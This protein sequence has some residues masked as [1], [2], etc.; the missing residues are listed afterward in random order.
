M[1]TKH[2][3]I[4]ASK[5][6]V[7]KYQRVCEAAHVTRIAKAFDREALGSIVV[8][9]REDGSYYVVDGQHRVAA[10]RVALGVDALLPC[11]VHFGLAYTREAALFRE[12]NFKRAVSSFGKF[13][14]RVEECEPTALDIVKILKERGLKY[15][16]G[17]AKGCVVAVGALDR[18]YRR[19]AET[20]RAV[21]WVVH[22]AFGDEPEAY[23][24]SLLFAVADTLDL[25]GTD[26][27]R[28]SRVLAKM[29]PARAVAEVKQCRD[30]GAP[31]H[32][33]LVKRYNKGLRGGLLAA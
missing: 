1:K 26:A 11:E 22:S 10:A 18:L 14:A 20:L 25:D 16:N 31:I 30:V 4:E 12:L 5:L 9:C 13:H 21:L 7:A 28:L 6:R 2:M 32:T 33:M 3:G 27:E 17:Q 19:G 29:T 8:S 23:N 15:S 24:A